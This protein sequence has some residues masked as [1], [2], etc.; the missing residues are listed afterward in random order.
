MNNHNNFHSSIDADTDDDLTN[1]SYLSSSSN[2]VPIKHPSHAN[3]N[4]FS[5]DSNPL[6]AFSSNVAGVSQNTDD[7]GYDGYLRPDS[8]VYVPL[9]TQQPHRT[10]YHDYAN[11][12][13]KP[14]DAT[15]SKLKFYYIQN[16]LHKYVAK[17]DEEQDIDQGLYKQTPTKRYAEFY[18]DKLDENRTVDDKLDDILTQ[19]KTHDNDEELFRTRTNDARSQKGQIFLVPFKLLT[20]VERPDNWVNTLTTDLNRKKRL[21]DQPPLLQDM[22]MTVAHELPKPF[23][24]RL[25]NRT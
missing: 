15:H 3:L 5:S 8:S 13:R 17:T 11:F 21:P 22:H 19:D 2:N 20:R 12:N 25:W 7:D 4:P 24:G 6:S 9:K 1:V 18:D 16:V 14:S 23:F 10:S